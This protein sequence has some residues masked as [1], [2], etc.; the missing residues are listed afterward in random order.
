VSTSFRR[1]RA[2]ACLKHPGN[3]TRTAD[4]AAC[5]TPPQPRGHA[6]RA[7]SVAIVRSPARWCA[8]RRAILPRW[9]YSKYPCEYSEYQ[10]EPGLVRM[11]NGQSCRAAAQ[12]GAPPTCRRCAGK[13]TRSDCATKSAAA[14]P[15][16]ALAAYRVP[17]AA[18]PPRQCCPQRTGMAR[19]QTKPQPRAAVPG[20]AGL[21]AGATGRD[22][23]NMQPGMLRAGG[24]KAVYAQELAHAYS[25]A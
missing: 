2:P 3:N 12:C 13:C 4:H 17:T 22:R 19:Q 5:S 1:I 7:I 11:T 20:G 16:G 14:V 8:L 6:A 24:S 25:Q 15:R 10:R 21:L 23:C 18:R 9:E